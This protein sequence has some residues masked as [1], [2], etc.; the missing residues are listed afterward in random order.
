MKALVTY[1]RESVAELRKVRWPSRE[2]TVRYSLIVVASVVLFTSVFGVI[3][4]GLSEL[5]TM[6]IER[7]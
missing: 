5:L 7:S 2:L 6:L 1:V 3:D 4:F